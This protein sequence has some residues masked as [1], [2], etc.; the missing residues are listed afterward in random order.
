MKIFNELTSFLSKL[1]YTQTVRDRKLL[2]KWTG[3][4]YLQNKIIL[5]TSA[6]KFCDQ[7]IEILHQEGQ[8]ILLNFLNTLSTVEGLGIDV[9]DCVKDFHDQ[10][11]NVPSE[12]WGYIKKRLPRV[13]VSHYTEI[14]RHKEFLERM[15]TELE[16]EGFEILVDKDGTTIKDPWPIKLLRDLGTCDAAVV[17]LNEQAL[18]VD[19]IYTESALLRWRYWSEKD[20]KLI[21]ICF[22]KNTIKKLGIGLW[23]QLEFSETEIINDLAESDVLESI[24]QKLSPLKKSSHR[25]SKTERREYELAKCFET[26]DEQYLKNALVEIGEHSGHKT[27]Q[28]PIARRLAREV[29]IAGP[30][31]FSH[32]LRN[33]AKGVESELLRFILE[34]I[35]PSWVDLQTAGIISKVKHKKYPDRIFYLNGRF[36]DTGK[37]FI[38]QACHTDDLKLEWSIIEVMGKAGENALQGTL[39]E[40]RMELIEKVGDTD[41]DSSDTDVEKVDA[42]INETLSQTKDL[43]GPVFVL[44]LSPLAEDGE[45]IELVRRTYPDLVIFILTGSAEITAQIKNSYTLKPLLDPNLEERALNDYRKNT[46]LLRR[47]LRGA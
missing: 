33:V 34:F 35:S 10:V 4:D 43:Y 15:C 5:E 12:S 38:R 45:L 11:A 22:G 23:T 6:L 30:G 14:P 41:I 19:N 27:T 24:K 46:A 31:T 21:P 26:A 36:A 28:F 42:F 32:L 39:H 29:L 8:D 25:Q 1:P 13:F 47:Y 7:L 2:L 17:L 16:K 3:T 18:T 37:M 9:R 20:F 40:I 44:F